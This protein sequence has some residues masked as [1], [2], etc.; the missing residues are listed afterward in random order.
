MTVWTHF[1]GP[2]QD[3][4]RGPCKWGALKLNLHYLLPHTIF[5]T[6]LVWP[7]SLPLSKDAIR[8]R[9]SLTGKCLFW[10][11]HS[12]SGSYLLSLCCSLLV[13]FRLSLVVQWNGPQSLLSFWLIFSP[14]TSWNRSQVMF[15]PCSTVVPGTPVRDKFSTSVV[16]TNLDIKNCCRLNGIQLKNFFFLI[17]GC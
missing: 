10:N 6:W 15:V 13:A 12:S 9:E 7:Y 5:W 14:F 17:F 2:S 4:G 3:L 1:T 11:K 16:Q 8:W